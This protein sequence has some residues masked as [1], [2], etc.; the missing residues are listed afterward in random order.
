MKKTPDRPLQDRLGAR[1]LCPSGTLARTLWLRDPAELDSTTA[2]AWGSGLPRALGFR[3]TS[4]PGPALGSCSANDV[5]QGPGT[6]R[7]VPGYRCPGT[8]WRCSR[9]VPLP[10][11]PPT[12]SHPGRDTRRQSFPRPSG[13]FGPAHQ[14]LEPTSFATKKTPE[15]LTR[16]TLVQANTVLHTEC[17]NRAVE[18]RPGFF[19]TKTPQRSMPHRCKTL[20]D[21]G[22]RR[23]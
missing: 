10:D 2:S 18:R 16:G 19:G 4:P 3:S 12:G 9:G 6:R 17:Q 1:G 15:G 5:S 13:A 21:S 14:P 22:A 20:L 11:A 7:Q 8:S 23:P